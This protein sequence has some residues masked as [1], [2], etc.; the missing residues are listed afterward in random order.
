MHDIYTRLPTE[1]A[2]GRVLIVA[3]IPR[4][5]PLPR[6]RVLQ[7]I[8]AVSTSI[9]GFSGVVASTNS[10]SKEET[11]FEQ[12]TQIKRE[13]G[14]EE[15]ERF[16][17]AHGIEFDS[18]AVGVTQQ[19]TGTS[20]NSEGL[21]TE[22]LTCVEPDDDCE[23]EMKV[24]MD[25]ADFP[26]AGY[27]AQM[28][29][30]YQYI[31]YSNSIIGGPVLSGPD[32]IKDAAGFGWDNNSWDI[33]TPD[34]PVDSMGHPEHGDW[35]GGSYSDRGGTLFEI[36][37]AATVQADAQSRSDNGTYWA[38]AHSIVSLDQQSGHSPGDEIR[39]LVRHT[40]GSTSTNFSFTIGVGLTGPSIGIGFSKSVQIN[41]EDIGNNPSGER[42]AV[43]A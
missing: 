22:S 15:Y 38:S 3:L 4:I 11:L 29:V 40:W 9:A 31:Y 27:I 18:A 19:E 1:I 14:H 12:A 39:G 10:S 17:T 20:G 30:N 2:Y 13:Q 35:D 8:G 42:L 6:R 21:S 41:D 34:R 5:D 36:Q 26:V 32:A 16:L 25:L 28:A 37:P 23:L 7:S 43:E 33:K 24:Y